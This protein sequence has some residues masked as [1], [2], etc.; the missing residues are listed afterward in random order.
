MCVTER[1]RPRRHKEKTWIDAHEH[2]TRRNRRTDCA[3][4][5][6][7]HVRSVVFTS[8][9]PL[10]VKRGEL[11][12]VMSSAT[13]TTLDSITASLKSLSIAAENVVSH[14]AATSPEE[15]KEAVMA[16]LSDSYTSAPGYTKTLLFKP[17]TA[18]TAKPVPVLVVARVETET[19][20]GALGKEINQKEMRLAAPE[21]LS[22][23]LGA[24]K[25]DGQFV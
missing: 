24:T 14:V 10:S 1:A 22:E 4:V 21:L 12:G 15:W 13:S 8:S 25:D 23:F 2:T 3:K 6:N 17:K 18:K 20:T 19:N 5:H 7:G 16:S 9:L 11:V